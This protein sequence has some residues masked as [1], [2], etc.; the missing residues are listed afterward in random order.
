MEDAHGAEYALLSS[1]IVMSPPAVKEGGSLTALT[2][3]V[4][5]CAPDVSVPPF[6][7][8]PSSTRETVTVALPFAFSAS[9]KVNTPAG[10]S[11]GCALNSALLSFEVLNVTA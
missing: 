10:E 4:N 9:V 1:K 6:A 5:V 3:I 8:P 2:V 11:D 7:V